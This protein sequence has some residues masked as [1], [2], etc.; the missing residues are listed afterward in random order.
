MFSFWKKLTEI[1]NIKIGQDVI[2][3]K[4]STNYSVVIVAIEKNIFGKIR[5]TARETD[6]CGE[7]EWG[8][9]DVVTTSDLSD[10]S[11]VDTFCTDADRVNLK[12]GDL[13]KLSGGDEPQYGYIKRIVLFDGMYV[14]FGNLY[15]TFNV[16]Y[17]M[18]SD[19]VKFA[20]TNQRNNNKLSNGDYV[21]IPNY[22]YGIIRDTTRTLFENDQIICK[23]NSSDCRRLV[24]ANTI[25]KS[26]PEELKMSNSKLQKIEEMKKKLA[27][28]EA[29]IRA[30]ENKLKQW[31]PVGGSYYVSGSGQ[32]ARAPSVDESRMFGT[33]RPTEDQAT[34]A[35]DEMRVFNRLL[36]YRDEFEPDFVPDWNNDCWDKFYVSY[37]YPLRAWRVVSARDNR[38]LGVVYFSKEVAAELARKLNS[39]EVVL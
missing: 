31:E 26:E 27:E 39:G 34:K 14:V 24:H 38:I 7:F 8:W 2:I 23:M 22:G 5:V 36:A 1:G 21:F 10:I 11:D 4:F 18:R 19:D 32:V 6:F 30:E 16:T 15:K 35:R 33:E 37:S 28:L 29:E 13:V 3:N 25:I 20:Y 9:G 12:I 17:R